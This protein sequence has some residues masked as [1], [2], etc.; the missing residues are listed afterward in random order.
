MRWFAKLCKVGTFWRAVRKAWHRNLTAKCNWTE[1]ENAPVS[2]RS[3]TVCF[4]KRQEGHRLHRRRL[5]CRRKD[6]KSFSPF[7]AGFI[8]SF[9]SNRSK[10]SIRRVLLYHAITSVHEEQTFLARSRRRFYSW[11]ES[12]RGRACSKKIVRLMLEWHKFDSTLHI[13][14]GISCWLGFSVGNNYA[15]FDGNGIQ[16]NFGYS[17]TSL[18]RPMSRLQIKSIQSQPVIAWL[19]CVYSIRLALAKEEEIDHDLLAN[20]SEKSSVFATL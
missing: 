7:F 1:L 12:E 16:H 5:R 13:Q 11:T 2:L 20:F 14:L 8:I 10:P 9:L 4:S 19:L 15:C 3:T 18:G 6:L 17:L